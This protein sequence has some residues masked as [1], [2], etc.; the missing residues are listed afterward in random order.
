MAHNVQMQDLNSGA[1]L[2]V[3]SVAHCSQF[4]CKINFDNMFLDFLFCTLQMHIFNLHKSFKECRL[5]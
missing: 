2:I 1:E 5:F 4:A 3:S